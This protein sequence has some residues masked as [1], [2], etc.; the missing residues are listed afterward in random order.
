MSTIRLVLVTW[1]LQL[2][3][4]SRS[5]FDG[6]LGLLWPLFFATTVFLMYRASGAE[7]S[8]LLSAA[9]GA[10]VMGIWSATS[11][12]ASFTL[13]QERRQGTL[14]LL[15]A[16]PRSF[17][18]LIFPVT[19]SMATVG[20]YSMAATLLWGRFVFGIEI[21]VADPVVFVLSTLVAVVGIGMLGFLLAIATVRYR[22]AW[23]VGSALEIPVWLICGFLV[24]LDLLPAWVRPISWLLAPTW[25]MSAIRGAAEGR[26]V[27]VDLLLCVTLGA[28]YGFI[29]MFVSRHML[30][31]A[32]RRATLALS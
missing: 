27:L 12:S 14:E 5:A 17:P 7:G 20:A 2:K 10:S 9:V 13:Q 8:A 26:S 4:R 18:L 32:R 3:I 22:S 25:G 28:A 6:L 30:N 1:W 21:A 11:T 29:G 23:A 24:P 16:A 19:L 15:V 31:S